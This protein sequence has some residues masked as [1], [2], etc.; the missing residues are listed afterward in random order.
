[1]QKN[2]Q[3]NPKGG[4]VAKPQSKDPTNTLIFF[5]YNPRKKKNCDFIIAFEKGNVKEHPKYFVYFDEKWS[6][7]QSLFEQKKEIAQK[8]IRK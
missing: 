1:M 5:S 7:N 3:A 6:I 8:E 2:S 4:G